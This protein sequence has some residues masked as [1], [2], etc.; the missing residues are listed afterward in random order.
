MELVERWW[1][2]GWGGARRDIWLGRD[3]DRWHLWWCERLDLDAGQK[4]LNLPE[5]TA[6]RYVENL[7]RTAPGEYERWRQ[8]RIEH[9]PRRART[10]ADS[11]DQA[12]PAAR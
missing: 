5:E 9:R 4:R 12:R 1:N 7:K 6:R 3:G 8:L 2:G 11:P 10:S